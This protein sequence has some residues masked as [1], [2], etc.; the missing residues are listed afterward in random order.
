MLDTQYLPIL[1]FR[2]NPQICQY[3]WKNNKFSGKKIPWEFSCSLQFLVPVPRLTR[4]MFFIAQFGRKRILCTN[5]VNGMLHLGGHPSIDLIGGCHAF[6][7]M[8]LSS[9][10]L[11]ACKVFLESRAT[12]KNWS[13]LGL[14]HFQEFSSAPKN[15]PKRNNY[16]NRLVK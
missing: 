3:Y 15:P 5:C 2:K 16:D 13:K 4:N 9:F 11:Q 12:R 1:I 10:L 6:I 8:P 14:R 7:G